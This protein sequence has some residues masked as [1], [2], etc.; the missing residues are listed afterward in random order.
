[1]NEERKTEVGEQRAALKP[2]PFCGSAAERCQTMNCS[3]VKCTNKG[4]EAVVGAYTQLA[5]DKGWNRRATSER[6]EFAQILAGLKARG[7]ITQ[8]DIER[9]E[10]DGVSRG[11][12]ENAEVQHGG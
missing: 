11:D 5:A 8:A 2:C 9:L 3:F 10:R 4:C 7:I 12:A 1:M 6:D